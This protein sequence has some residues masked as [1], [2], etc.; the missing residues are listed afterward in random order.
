[1]GNSQSLPVIN[2]MPWREIKKQKN[3][4]RMMMNIALIIM[5]STLVQSINVWWQQR[6]LNGIVQQQKKV[7]DELRIVMQR[8]Q[9][10]ANKLHQWQ[11]LVALQTRLKER[12]KI[13][14]QWLLLLSQQL[15][16]EAYLTSL[17]YEKQQILLEGLV[18]DSSMIELWIIQL[19][20]SL[21]T[22]EIVLKALNF[23][24]G[25]YHFSMMIQSP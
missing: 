25:I 4:F 21:A 13:L 11:E 7:R 23:Q 3:R 14:M 12:Q 22:Q 17:M 6:P 5:L 16:K 20:T 1:M 19:K 2:L 10:Y 18:K 9:V 15:P 8:E 24:Q